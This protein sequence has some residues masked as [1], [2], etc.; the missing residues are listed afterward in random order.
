M[1][2][3][4][5]IGSCRFLCF[6]TPHTRLRKKKCHV[7]YR[8][9]PSILLRLSWS[10]A[11]NLSAYSALVVSCFPSSVPLLCSERLDQA[12]QDQHRQANV[13]PY[14]AARHSTVHRRT[15]RH[16]AVHLNK[17]LPVLPKYRQD[18]GTRTENP[19]D[20]GLKEQS[21]SATSKKKK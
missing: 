11:P 10:R 5:E 14:N 9:S 4:A 16:N 6:I 12:R 8:I 15:A 20:N 18:E 3:L 1:V 21:Y 2:F 13:A 17:H 19:D 7:P